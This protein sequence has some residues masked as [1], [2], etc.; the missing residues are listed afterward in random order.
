MRSSIPASTKRRPLAKACCLF[1][2][3]LFQA[4]PAHGETHEQRTWPHGPQPHSI[5][6]ERRRE[7]TFALSGPLWVHAAVALRSRAAKR[8]APKERGLRRRRRSHHGHP[9]AARSER[10]RALF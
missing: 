2:P 1:C 9:T 7:I 4:P 3:H 6:G 5:R 10:R 8:D